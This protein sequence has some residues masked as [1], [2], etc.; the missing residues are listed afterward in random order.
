[1]AY[2]QNKEA[3]KGI[4]IINM[5]NNNCFGKLY[6]KLEECRSCKVQNSCSRFFYAGK[7]PPLKKCPE[8]YIRNACKKNGRF[9]DKIQ[10]LTKEDF[11]RMP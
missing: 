11:A 7:N 9:S 2:T 8:S 10:P 3:K 4:I 1:M 6:L 5:D